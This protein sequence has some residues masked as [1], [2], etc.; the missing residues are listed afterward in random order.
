MRRQRAEKK[1]PMTEERGAVLRPAVKL[2]LARQGIFFGPG[3]A[4]LLE[5]I[6]ETG[7]IQEACAAMELS[8]SKGSRIIKNT[9]KEFG[10]KLLERWTGGTGGGGSRLTPEG[11]RMLGCYR[12]LEAKVQ[13]SAEELFKEC[14]S[15]GDE[16]REDGGEV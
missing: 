6:E 9:E 4:A 5:L 7:S 13:Q 12:K 3:T 15:L 2:R 11:K 16:P 8:Y 10:V 14:F 1:S